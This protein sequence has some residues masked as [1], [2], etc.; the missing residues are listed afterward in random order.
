MPAALAHRISNRFRQQTFVVSNVESVMGYVRRGI[1][2]ARLRVASSRPAVTRDDDPQWGDDYHKRMAERDALAESRKPE[3]WLQSKQVALLLIERSA[4]A[5]DCIAH[6]PATTATTDRQHDFASLRHEGYAVRQ[7][8]DRYHKLTPM[9]ARAARDLI[10]A[11]AR[12]IGLHHVS[13]HHDSIN[14][15]KARC[16]CGWHASAART[17]NR[18]WIAPLQ[19]AASRHIADPQEWI[20]RREAGQKIID[21]IGTSNTGT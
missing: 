4:A 19:V 5:L 15:H 14:E 8:G 2:A 6:L 9:G 13:Y 16:T 21:A 17:G 20:R 7:L 3:N 1:S 12:R 10:S 18:N 11:I